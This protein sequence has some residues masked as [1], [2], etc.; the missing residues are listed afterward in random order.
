MITCIFS[1]ISGELIV[2]YKDGRRERRYGRKIVVGETLRKDSIELTGSGLRS[3]RFTENEFSFG[4][5]SHVI[6]NPKTAFLIEESIR[7]GSPVRMYDGLS[8]SEIKVAAFDIEVASSGRFPDP[9]RPEDRIIMF[10]FADNTGFSGVVMEEDEARLLERFSAFVDYVKPDILVGHNIFRFDLPY[11]LKR[12]AMLGVRPFGSRSVSVYTRNKRFAERYQTFDVV[13][14]EGIEMADTYVLA[15]MHD[16]YVR[17]MEGYGLKDLVRYFGLRDDRV[18]EDVT[19]LDYDELVRD[20]A[21]LKRLKIYA[22]Q[23]AEDA[24]SLFNRLGLAFVE[25]ARRLPFTL[26]DAYMEGSGRMLDI[27]MCSEYLSNLWALPY[28]PEPKRQKAGGYTDAFLRGVHRGGIEHVDVASMYP[29][30]MVGWG[31]KPAHDERDVF[32][33]ILRPMMEERLR[34]KDSFKKT[35]NV[36]DDVAASA[37]KIIINS[38]YGMMGYPKAYF[39]DADAADF[40]AL[41]GQEILKNIIADVK[42]HGGSPILCDTDGVI[43]RGSKEVVRKVVE[44]TER[45]YG[46]RI[47][48]EHEKTYESILVYKKKNYVTYDGKK[49]KR[50]GGFFKS[51]RMEGIVKRTMDAMIESILKG[52]GE[53]KKILEDAYDMILSD[54]LPPED[55]VIS[56]TYTKDTPENS[57]QYTAMKKMK[58]K[59]EEGEKINFYIKRGIDAP[60]FMKSEPIDNYDYDYDIHHYAARLKKVCEALL[61][62][63]TE[64]SGGEQMTFF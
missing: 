55:V 30:I 43:L 60:L 5:S 18:I 35:G 36:E 63:V 37:L 9:S 11:L 33:R 57:P 64:K 29:S 24:L 62:A 52:V 26:T 38:A 14:V 25:V 58:Y 6:K 21:R 15:Q 19:N 8:L 51:R 17:D 31:V 27:S 3:L 32:Q 10:S 44:S 4:G 56:V 28:R 50:R 53:P 54:M 40:V 1:D 16:V 48:L 41:K 22:E 59:P 61:E 34:R 46:G 2:S 45:R 42:A 13:Q 20:P 23:D 47:K 7:R 12:G 39:S 49:I